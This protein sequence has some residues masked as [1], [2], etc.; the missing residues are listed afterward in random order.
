M[1]ESDAVWSEAESQ[2]YR[3]L[4]DFAVPERERQI[5]IFVSLVR[6]SSASGPVLDLCCGEGLISAALHAAFPALSIHAYDGSQSMLDETFRRIGA[7]D[8]LHG[9][10]IDLEARD[11]RRF[12]RGLRAVTSSL[13]V[14]HLDGPGKRRLF[15]D[16][17]AAL[18]PGGVFVLSDIILPTRPAGEAIAGQMW[19]EEVKRRSRDH[20]GTERAF[21]TFRET[22]WNHF[23]HGELD[24]IDKPSTLADHVDW[25]RDA[26]F[27]DVDIHWMLAGNA[28]FSA[29]KA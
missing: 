13:A 18:S 20:D 3:E 9:R 21:K 1:T 4:S 27:V 11:W 23:H 24:P 2:V 29:W 25:L 19:D 8:R 28:I 10:L 26:G 5:D 22:R 16:I 17:H 15:E 7:S 12:D 6:A 14:H